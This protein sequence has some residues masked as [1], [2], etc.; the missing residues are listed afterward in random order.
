MKRYK[1]G[2]TTGV[3]DMFHV[4]HLNVLRRAK[5]QCEHLIVG[6]STDELV[7]R[8]KNKTPIIPFADRMRIVQAI[9]YV[10]D[11]VPQID[12][13]KMAA[14]QKLQF[15][16]MFVGGD[17]QGTPQWADFERQFAPLGVDI[18]YLPHTDGISSTLLRERI[19]PPCIHSHTDKIK[20]GYTQGTF[21]LFHVGHLN[22]IQH[23]KQLCDYLIVGVNANKLVEEY[24]KKTPVVNEADRSEIISAVNCVDECHVVQTLDKMHAHTRFHFNTIFIGDDW[25]GNPRWEQTQIDLRGIGVDLVFLPH[26]EGISS[27]AIS[28]LIRHGV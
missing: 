2:Y 13:N 18:I 6:V 23:A 5:E 1:I 24:K 21:D 9:R 14:W 28:N 20:I 11:V 26:T 4:G 15:N 22:L 27:T 10:D 8:D 19:T 7:R 3:F 16:A 12:K 17:W 25:K